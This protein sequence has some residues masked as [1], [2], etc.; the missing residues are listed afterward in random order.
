MSVEFDNG[1]AFAAEGGR[2]MWLT[3]S[4]CGS[5]LIVDGSTPDPVEIHKRWHR[6]ITAMAALG[7]GL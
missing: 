3:C 7:V 5:A 4:V 2:A 1:R 6:Q